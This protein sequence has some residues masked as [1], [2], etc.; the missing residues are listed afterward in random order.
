MVEHL[1]ENALPCV[2]RMRHDR[3]RHPG[4]SVRCAVHRSAVFVFE[5]MQL[6]ERRAD[7]AVGL[8]QARPRFFVAAPS[9]AAQHGGEQ[10]L[11]AL[12]VRK[13]VAEF[14]IAQQHARIRRERERVIG[15]GADPFRHR[16]RVA[17]AALG[18]CLRRLAAA[19]DKSVKGHVIAEKHCIEPAVPCADGVAQTAVHLLEAVR[20]FHLQLGLHRS[21][22]AKHRITLSRRLFDSIISA[23]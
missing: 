13:I 20:F 4:G 15:R 3:R 5:Y 1:P 23:K 6:I 9:K 2:A 18:L 17:A 16:V 19:D 8:G 11:C 22:K 12:F 7:V 21:D 10:A 14:M